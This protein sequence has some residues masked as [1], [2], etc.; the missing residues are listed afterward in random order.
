M[1]CNARS[2]D[3]DVLSCVEK[4]EKNGRKKDKGWREG[5]IV[6]FGSDLSS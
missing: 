3:T 2:V 6:R 5:R 1:Q 4:E